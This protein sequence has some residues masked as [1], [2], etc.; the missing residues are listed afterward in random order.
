MS[1][2]TLVLRG[3]SEEGEGLGL[4]C[5]KSW[6]WISA[7]RWYWSWGWAKKKKKMFCCK[8]L[9]CYLHTYSIYILTFF[10]FYSSSNFSLFLKQTFFFTFQHRWNWAMSWNC[11]Q[12]CGRQKAGNLIHWLGTCIKNWRLGISWLEGNLGDSK[13]H[14]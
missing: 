6:K 4:E 14:S 5:D 3:H 10:V 7:G 1:W 8:A 11:S 13:E 9:F 2:K 12:P